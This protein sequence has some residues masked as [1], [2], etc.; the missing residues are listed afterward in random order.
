MTLTTTAPALLINVVAITLL[1]YTIYFR[2]HHRLDLLGAYVA[3]NLGVFCAVTLLATAEVGAGLGFALF[4]I[5]SIIRLRSS[6]IQQEEIGYYFVALTLGL[7]GG[8]GADS[9]EVILVL[10]AV[11]LV[12]MYV[13]DHPRLV[14]IPVE[15]RKIVI[16]AVYGTR[17][18]L[19]NDLE[20]RL[21]GKVLVCHV[22]DINY[23]ARTSTCDVRFRDTDAPGVTVRPEP[24]AEPTA[25]AQPCEVST[26]SGSIAVNGSV[27]TAGQWVAS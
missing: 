23:Q 3:L 12:G 17:E 5:L 4:G 7:V 22:T 24:P 25:P 26:H 19:I 6:S 27:P 8:L 14:K 16:D 21:G 15:R 20:E 11:L 2:R 1:A 13:I 9:L 10:D 18:E